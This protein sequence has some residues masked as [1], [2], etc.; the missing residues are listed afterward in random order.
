MR[1]ASLFTILVAILF[2]V[3]SIS[4]QVGA[5]GRNKLQKKIKKLENG[6]QPFEEV[7]IYLEVGDGEF[8]VIISADSEEPLRKLTVTAPN[9][10]RVVEIKSKDLAELSLSEISLETSLSS[11][12]QI[13][14]AYPEGTYLFSGRT[15]AGEK[16][17]GR[18]SLSYQILPA[19]SFSPSDGEEIDPDDFE[20]EWDAVTGAAGYIVEVENDDLGVSIEAELGP[21]ILS[22]E[23]S[24]DVLEPGE[25]YEVEVGAVHENGNVS[26]AESSFT[27]PEEEEGEVVELEEAEIF[28]EFNSTD[29]DLGIHIFFDGEPWEEVEVCGPDGEIF[30]VSNDGELTNIGST[31]LFTES[32]EP[33]LSEENLEEEMADFLARFPAGEYEFEG[34]TIEGDTL[35]GSAT[36]SH[37]LPAAPNLIF[38]DPEAEENVAD[39]ENTVIEWSDASEEGDPEIERYE[40]IVEFEEEETE[41]V[42]VFR[43]D[44]PADPEADTY[45]VP[46]PPEFFESLDGLEGEYKAEI[47]AIAADKNATIVENEFELE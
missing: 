38:P 26:V 34:K 41:R 7:D 22:F 29:L 11:I 39:P 2:A 24:D 12:G 5:K 17:F 28:F 44:I 46:V 20:I 25:E 9:D 15:A 33:P 10:N 19:P 6:S 40:V 47:I 8:E 14:A 36:L 32:A 42:F 4:Q 13:Q 21:E 18:A 43:V 1:R 27:V 45:S 37:D 31:E 23:V 35:E 3:V 30:E 16:L